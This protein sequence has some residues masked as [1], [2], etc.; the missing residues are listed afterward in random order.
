MKKNQP[1][2]IHE[3][4]EIFS[5]TQKENNALN[6][7]KTIYGDQSQNREISSSSSL[8]NSNP[9]L[10]DKK[11]SP[12]NIADKIEKVENLQKKIAEQGKLREMLSKMERDFKQKERHFIKY[13]F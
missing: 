12:G 4:R 5:L 7:A 13:E 2:K 6:V 3:P 1:F 9:K 10:T 8:E 11:Q